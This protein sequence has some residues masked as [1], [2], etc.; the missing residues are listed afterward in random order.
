M[1]AFDAAGNVSAQSS[2]ASATTPA[3]TPPPSASAVF[4]NVNSTTQ[5]TWKGQYGTDG[6]AIVNDSTSYPAYAQISV[7]NAS[8]Y[9][10][11]ASTADVR[12]LQKAVS[13][14]DRIASTWYNASSFTLDVN[15]SDG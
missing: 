4:L 1:V 9:T 13:S 8:A 5:G 7:S 6:Y 10:W 2:P 14:T 12:A 3:G 11:A 15:L